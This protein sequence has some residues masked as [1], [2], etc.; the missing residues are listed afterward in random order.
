MRV[1]LTNPR[2][3]LIFIIASLLVGPAII[4]FNP[5]LR[6]PDESAHFLRAFGISHGD[7]I[8]RTADAS[9]RRGLFLPAELHG[10]FAHFD[11]FREMRPADGLTWRELFRAYFDGRSTASGGLDPV[12]TP[13]EG[14]EGYS[15]VPYIPYAVVAGIADVLGSDFLIMIYSMRIAGLLAW[16]VIAAYAIGIAP[17]LR[18]MFFCVAML[19]G[20]LY[21]RTV[22]SADGA[23]LSTTLLVVAL[24]MQAAGKSASGAAERAF[25]MTVSSLTKPPQ[26]VLLLLEG[27][28][29]KT[30]FRPLL[31]VAAPGIVLSLSWVLAVDADVGAWRLRGD[32]NVPSAEFDP[33]HRLLFLLD[34]P[35]KFASNII[36]SLD[37]SGELW[38]Q[39]IGVFGWLDVPMRSFVYPMVTVLLVLTLFDELGLGR[40]ARL[41]VSIVSAMTMVSYC[42]AVCAIFFITLTPSDADRIHGLQGRYFL[43]LL[44]LLALFLSAIVNRRF[45]AT[46]ASAAIIGALVSSCATIDAL[47]RFHWAAS[48]T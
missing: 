36:T 41:R 37:Y 39:L 17:C 14:S 7:F 11:R 24:C 40:R 10:Q 15:P 27:L 34:H 13:Y 26:L 31:M 32:N 44:P 6:G 48:T 18:W 4:A 5:P 30:R 28:H 3:A 12:F 35:L 25:W 9:G 19:P 23:V 22:I 42:L 21:Q 8:P 1:R 43:I 38:R 45:G 2:P 16:T 47:W 46:A 20:A 33:R 29:E